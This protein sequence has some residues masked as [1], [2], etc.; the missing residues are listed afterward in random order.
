[1]PFEV[2]PDHLSAVADYDA[3][4]RDARRREAIH[5]V[6]QHGASGQRQHRLG[7]VIRQGLHARSAPGGQYDRSSL[8]ASRRMHA[9]P[10]LSLP[11]MYLESRPRTDL[12]AH[13]GYDECEPW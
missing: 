2:V 1:M 4:P 13:F 3:D 5:L 7:A 12:S 11:S 6:R 8:F 10:D 9:P